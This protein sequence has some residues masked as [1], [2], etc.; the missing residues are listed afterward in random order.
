MAIDLDAIKT[1]L[2]TKRGELL[3]RIDEM[4]E[5]HEHAVDSIEAGGGPHDLEDIAGDMADM[6]NRQSIQANEQALLQDVEQ[7]LDRIRQGSYGVCVN[8]GKPVGE[9][10]LEVLPWAA[11]CIVCEGQLEQE[12]LAED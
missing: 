4:T 7:A 12:Q 11:R 5:P 6:Q 2:E 8:C 9:K 1:R 3:Q 10:R